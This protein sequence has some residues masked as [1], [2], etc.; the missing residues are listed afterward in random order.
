[1]HVY[2]CMCVCT[3][4]L[5]VGEDACKFCPLS[6]SSPPRTSCFFVCF[7]LIDIVVQMVVEVTE[8]HIM[9]M[10]VIMAVMMM[11]GEDVL[12]PVKIHVHQVRSAEIIFAFLF[13]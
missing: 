4:C 10:S 13:T 11:T 9:M 5:C 2:V 3:C 1:M 7:F 8:V 6:F 12:T